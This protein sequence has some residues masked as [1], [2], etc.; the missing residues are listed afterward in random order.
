MEQKINIAELLKDCPKGMELDC[1]LFSAKV[2]Y[3]GLSKRIPTHPIVVQTEHGFEFEL[4][5][6][7]QIHNIVGS[8]CVIFPKGKTSWEGFVPPCQFKDGDIIFTHANC[9]KVGVG[10]T[11]IS[12]F[13]ERRNGGVATYVDYAED[14]SDYYSDL[15][16]DKALLCMES[17]ILRQRFAT[18]EEKEKLFQAIKDNGYK[19]NSETKTLEKLN[20]PKEEPIEDKGNISDGYHT[21]NELYEYRLLY[22]ASMFNELAKQG[23]YDVHKS[24]KH[25]DGTIPFGDENWFIVQAELPTGQISNHYEMKDW[26]LFQV[27]VKEKANLYDG[28]TPQDVAKRLRMFLTSDKLIESKFKIGD[29]VRHKNNHNVVVT[30][31]NIEKD[32]YACGTNK[33]FWFTE[34]NDYE[35]IHEPKFKVGD[36]IRKKGDKTATFTISDIGDLCYYCG[37][38]VICN[39]CYQ[40]DYELVPNKFDINTLKPLQPV[41]VR[42]SNIGRWDITFYELYDSINKIYPYRTLGGCIYKQCIPYEENE[43]LLGKTNDCNDFYKTWE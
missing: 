2:I 32:Y 1:I 16:G 6:Y 27:P 3:K 36:R 34:Q 30:I 11:W 7:G 20:I 13:K 14:G 18:E 35:L 41:L 19:W 31:T 43:Y 33:A 22:N 37:E 10:N 38:Y 29:K 5:Q 28:H 9:L 24:K 23:L 12:I 25:S 21:F 40:D 42:D 39:I 26:D 17:D 8:N 4:T 15:D